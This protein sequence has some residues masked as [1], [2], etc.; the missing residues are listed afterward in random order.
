[1]GLVEGKGESGG[2]LIGEDG[3]GRRCGNNRRC[4][5]LLS[6]EWEGGLEVASEEED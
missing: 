6:Q 3:W 4:V 5:V 1:M 2:H